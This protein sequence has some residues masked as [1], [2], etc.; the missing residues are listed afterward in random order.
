ML[1]REIR[2]SPLKQIVLECVALHNLCK[3]R[4]LDVPL[5]QDFAGE[6]AVDN[7]ADVEALPP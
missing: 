1:H 4:N 2:M 5:Q 7:P 3:E 6:E